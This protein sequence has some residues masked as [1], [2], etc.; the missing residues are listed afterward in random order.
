MK[1][2]RWLF[3]PQP[4][5]HRVGAWVCQECRPSIVSNYGPRCWNCGVAAPAWHAQEIFKAIKKK[6]PEKE[7]G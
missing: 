7:H 2:W 5:I 6:A 3:K 1:F 4:Q